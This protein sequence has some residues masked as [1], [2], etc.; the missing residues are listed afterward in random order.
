MAPQEFKELQTER[1]ILKPL[2]ATFDFANHLFNVISKNLEFFKYMPW[3][4]IKCA[5][6]EFDFLRSA[7]KGWKNKTKA[8]HGMYLR[9]GGDFVGVCTMFGIDWGEEVGEIG[10][11]L[12]PKYAK[13]GFMSEA[14]AAVAKEFFDMGFERIIIKANPENIASC[15]TAEKC[16]FVREGIMRSYGFAPGLN[17]RED[18]ALYAKVR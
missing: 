4:D 9:D 12:D 18:V 2:V 8:T 7:E 13:H 11:W 6:Q 14:V 3:L 1:L 5:E 17:K 10:Y 16:G 15:K